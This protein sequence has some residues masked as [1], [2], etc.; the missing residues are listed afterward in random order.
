MKYLKQVYKQ[1]IMEDRFYFSGLQYK[2]KAKYKM[3]LFGF[4]PDILNLNYAL[5]NLL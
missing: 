3:G 4:Y 5:E 2:L 1:C